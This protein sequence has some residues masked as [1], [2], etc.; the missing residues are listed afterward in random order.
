M[1]EVLHAGIYISI[2]D[3]GRKGMSALGISKGGAMD[4]HSFKLANSVVGNDKNDACLEV[5]FGGGKFLFKNKTQICLTGADFNPMINGET[6]RMNTPILIQKG[7]I[8]SFGKRKYGVYT[9]IGIKGGVQSESVLGSRSQFKYITSKFRLEKGDKVPIHSEVRVSNKSNFKIDPVDIFDGNRMDCFPGPEFYLLSEHQKKQLTQPFRLSNE[10]NRIGVV[11]K[12]EI[13]NDFPQLLSSAV[14]PGT[15]QLTPSGKLI[16][17]LRDCQ[18]T[19]GYPRILQ[20]DE[21]S[22]NKLSQKFTDDWINF[23]LVNQ[24]SQ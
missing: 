15:I 9:Y 4:L 18:P 17:L 24:L 2:Q 1:I 12:E 23:S 21:F 7:G 3:F 13:P 16:V 11:L 14:L 20:L 5:T 8:L 6:I 19:G 22:V 10:C